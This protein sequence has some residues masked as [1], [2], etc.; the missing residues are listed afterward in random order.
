MFWDNLKIEKEKR[1]ENGVTKKS[2]SISKTKNEN[3]R[4]NTNIANSGN[5]IFSVFNDDIHGLSPQMQSLLQKAN[6]FLDRKDVYDVNEVE[7]NIQ[8]ECN[9]K[10]Y[11][12]ITKRNVDLHDK[13]PYCFA[14]RTG[15]EIKC[16]YCGSSLI[17]NI[18]ETQN[19]MSYKK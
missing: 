7:I 8:N 14:P 5:D 15:N 12:S 18:Y 1:K 17:D 9:G 19:N 10:V 3:L 6:D 2:F 11:N 4:N 13:C 16:L